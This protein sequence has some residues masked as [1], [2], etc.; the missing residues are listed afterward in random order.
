MGWF[1]FPTPLLNITVPAFPSS[2][3]CFAGTGNLTTFDTFGIAT[4]VK[5]F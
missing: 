5:Y 2:A 1:L 3:L 4:I